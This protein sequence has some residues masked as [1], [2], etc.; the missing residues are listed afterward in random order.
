VEI[1]YVG[2]LVLAGVVLTALAAYLVYKFSR[3]SS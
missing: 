3:R 2:L 1:V